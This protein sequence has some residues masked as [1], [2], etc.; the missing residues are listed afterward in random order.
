MTEDFIQF[1]SEI[2]QQ[3]DTINQELSELRLQERLIQ[4]ADQLTPGQPCLLCGSTEHPQVIHSPS[5]KSAIE[6]KQEELA[7]LRRK[8]ASFRVLQSDIQKLSS[9]QEAIG[10]M[11]NQEEQRR[12]ELRAKGKEHQNLHRWPEYENLSSEEIDR[13]LT[14]AQQEQSELSEWQQMRQ[15]GQQKVKEIQVELER[16]RNQQQTLLQQQSSLTATEEQRQ[17]MLEIYQADDY[18]DVTLSSI[19]E[20]HQQKQG[21]LN[22]IEQQYEQAQLTFQKFQNG[23]GTLEGRYEAIQ[24]SQEKLSW[25]A[26]SLNREIL[27]LMEEK[28]FEGTEEIRELIALELDVDSEE[29]A[30]R[31]FRNR[32][33]SAEV[34]LHKLQTEVKGQ[35]Y[36]PDH[37][38]QLR[39]K[40]QETT[41][42]VRQ[43]QEQC[44]LLRQRIRDWQ[45]KQKRTQT[46]QKELA[47]Q[48]ERE[49]NLKEL[50]SLVSGQWFCEVCLYCIIRELMPSG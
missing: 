27:V 40:A 28:D 3:Q 14:V 2:H 10:K 50:S 8:E 38:R 32:L 30:V 41:N 21:H 9:Q 26:E 4:A 34:T 17:S 13:R 31:G 46:I 25:K 39:M 47:Q 37:H 48:Q 7:D 19:Q 29:Q 5:V 49:G 42:Q 6:E 33:H 36:D 23:L 22:D 20:L 11:N 24:E 16:V 12:G 43:Q 45:S 35:H 1:Q 44:T 18:K 15:R